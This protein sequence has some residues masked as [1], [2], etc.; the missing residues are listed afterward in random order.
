[1]SG[2]SAALLPTR[3]TTPRSSRRRPPALPGAPRARLRSARLPQAARC[4]PAA[5]AAMLFVRRGSYECLVGPASRVQPVR[6][7]GHSGL[8]H[9]PS[10]PACCR[11][12]GRRAFSRLRRRRQESS[13]PRHAGRC[14]P[15]S[16][17]SRSGQ[18]VLPQ[19]R[20]VTL[21]LRQH[22]RL[23]RRSP[24]Q[25]RRRHYR[26]RRHRH[27]SASQAQPP[28]SSRTE[29]RLQ[30]RRRARPASSR[31]PRAAPRRSLRRRQRPRRRLLPAP[32]RLR[33]SQQRR[34]APAW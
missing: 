1:M 19:Q 6:A 21:S 14:L 31:A 22:S 2:T 8:V 30:E 10:V 5:G 3:S 20:M 16:S 25:R 4:A 13:V 34:H 15:S 17:S 18:A 23:A 9:R 7:V 26:R 33:R 12:A 28:A 11:A 29:P 24:M 32:S 27:S